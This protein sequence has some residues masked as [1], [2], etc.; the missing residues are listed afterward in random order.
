[1]VN[2][3]L[4]VVYFTDPVCYYKYLFSRA[5]SIWGKKRQKISYRASLNFDLE[6]STCYRSATPSLNTSEITSWKL[7][8][9]KVFTNFELF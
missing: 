7:M 9:S 4:Q 5:V 3:M 6:E 8:F 2:T 1:M